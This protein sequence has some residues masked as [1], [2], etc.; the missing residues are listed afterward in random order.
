MSS[1]F[2]NN[3]GVVLLD[4]G[5]SSRLGQAKQL[6][7]FKGKSLVRRAALI[8]L[9]IT[10]KLIVVAGAQEEKIKEELAGLDASIC[11]NKNYEEGIA[12]SIHAGLMTV[13]EKFPQI[14]AV[15]FIVGDESVQISQF[16]L[17]FFFLCTDYYNQFITY[18][19][20]N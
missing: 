18:C 20:S 8:G 17:Y 19:Q 11:I 10:D 13:Q 6:L 16:F 12:S 2:Q 4:A 9:E 14:N 3:Y 15:M 1:S 7:D 5:K